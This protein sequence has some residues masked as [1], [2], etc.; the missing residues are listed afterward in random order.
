MFLTPRELAEATLD[1]CCSGFRLWLT[2][3][4]GS[5]AGYIIPVHERREPTI[6][7]LSGAKVISL[8]EVRAQRKKAGGMR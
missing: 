7:T 5:S 1:A 6:R 3:I 4:W 2:L 8:C